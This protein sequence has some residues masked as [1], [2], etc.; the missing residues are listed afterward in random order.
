MKSLRPLPSDLQF[1]SFI[2]SRVLLPSPQ[3]RVIVGIVRAF[4]F[5]V[6]SFVFSPSNGWSRLCYRTVNVVQDGWSRFIGWCMFSVARNRFEA[7]ANLHWSLEDRRCIT[8]PAHEF[9]GAILTLFQWPSNRFC[10]A[11]LRCQE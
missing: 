5:L 9:H 4:S 3:S 6:C 1:R 8:R 11:W 7:A 2:V 10:P